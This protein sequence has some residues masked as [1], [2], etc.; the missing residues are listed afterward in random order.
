[1]NGQRFDENWLTDY[2]TLP[3]A[4][5]PRTYLTSQQIDA[6]EPPPDGEDV[7]AALAASLFG[8]PDTAHSYAL[9]DAARAPGLVEVLETLRLDHACLFRGDADGP[10]RLGPWLVRLEPQGKFTRNL[11]R[12]SARSWHLWGR[13]SFILLR[14]AAGL[15]DLVAHF[16]RFTKVRD[17][18]GRMVFFRF[19]DPLV[20]ALY[21]SA[22]RHDPTR[23]EQIFALPGGETAEVIAPLSTDSALHLALVP[24]FAR[25]QPRRTINL[26]ARDE[27]ILQEIAFSTFARQLLPWLASEYPAQ[28]AARPP[29]DQRAIARHV[30]ATGR[31][32]GLSMKEDFAFLAQIMMT[33]GGWVWDDDT[34]PGLR[35]LIAEAPAP[36]AQALAEGYGALQGRS[37]QADLL[38]DWPAL[39]GWLAAL[40][41][42]Q[43]VTP[44]TFRR[45]TTKFMP[46][47]AGLIAG[48]I[49]STRARLRDAGLSAQRIEGKAVVLTLLLGPRFFE[50]P[51]RPWCALPPEAAINAAWHEIIQ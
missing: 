35:D 3:D 11:F 12:Q 22:R 1:M 21:A 23:L 40:P 8:A 18:R 36:K 49:A 46:R 45:L 47:S 9:I 31:R 34:L 30:V 39:R 29:A 50:D 2:F 42:D 7:P 32:A 15:T 14:S 51:L 6:I 26:D 28:L 17:R 4:G 20:I 37:P 5:G 25:E 10:A 33:S 43:A 13:D 41:E 44:E 27:A 48:A 16:R 24:G 19:W 38:G